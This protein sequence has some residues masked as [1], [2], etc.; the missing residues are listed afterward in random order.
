VSGTDVVAAVAG[1]VESVVSGSVA[2]VV[3]GSV[4]AGVVSTV[5]A[6][7]ATVIGAAVVGG[8][9]MVVVDCG[10]A[11][12]VDAVDGVVFDAE[13]SESLL[14]AASSATEHVIATRSFIPPTYTEGCANSLRLQT[15]QLHLG[16]P[17]VGALAQ[18]Q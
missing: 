11:V 7:V 5:G 4:T 10:D 12:E 14:Q 8:A 15:A 9:A 2:S 13:L 3:S 1:S 17:V 16:D 6:T 18:H